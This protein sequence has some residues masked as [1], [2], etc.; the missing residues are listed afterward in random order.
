[1]RLALFQPDIPQNTGTMIRLCA[2][3]GVPMDIIE[4]CGFIFDDKKL[5]RAGMDY[6]EIANVTRHPSW[7]A[8]YNLYKDSHR[9]I[10]MTTKGSVAYT[11]FK[12]LPNDILLMGSESKG[13]PDFV[14][15]A[16]NARIFVPMKNN[17]RSLNVAITSAIA[18]SEALRQQQ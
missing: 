18:L 10:L 13:A 15:N 17:A 3:L 7:E 5:L 11:D 16:V 1:M 6:I 12:F 2:C 8:F 14:H 9:I 4:P